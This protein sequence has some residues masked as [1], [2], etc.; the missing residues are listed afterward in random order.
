[1]DMIR[2][3]MLQQGED[4]HF[5]CLSDMNGRRAADSLPSPLLLLPQLPPGHYAGC[6]PSMRG[7]LHDIPCDSRARPLPMMYEAMHAPP[8]YIYRCVRL[9]DFLRYHSRFTV[10]TPRMHDRFAHAHNIVK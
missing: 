1:M 4:C 3:W 10:F 8:E 6:L 2:L 5:R 9:P 7:Q